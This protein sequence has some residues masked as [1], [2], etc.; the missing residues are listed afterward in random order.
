MQEDE[1]VAL[2]RPVDHG[3]KAKAVRLHHVLAGGHWASPSC[4]EVTTDP[5]GRWSVGAINYRMP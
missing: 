5:T 2:R 3:P 1:H 4:G